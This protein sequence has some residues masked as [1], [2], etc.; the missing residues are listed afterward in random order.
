MIYGKHMKKP[1]RNNSTELH[2]RISRLKFF[3]E[4]LQLLKTIF[5]FFH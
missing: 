4:L 2:N 3:L 1:M 5:D